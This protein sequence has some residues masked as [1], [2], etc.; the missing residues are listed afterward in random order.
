MLKDSETDGTP[1]VEPPARV[2]YT[3]CCDT[4]NLSQD[5]PC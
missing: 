4:A 2:K 5:L 3:H 1:G